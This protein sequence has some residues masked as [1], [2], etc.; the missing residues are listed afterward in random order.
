MARRKKQNIN[1]TFFW[2]G[3]AV[4]FLGII[5]ETTPG[6]IYGAIGIIVAAFI[7]RYVVRWRARVNWRRKVLSSGIHNIDVMKGETFEQFLKVLFEERGYQVELT[8][9]SGDF[10]ADL[11]MTKDGRRI[12]VQ[13]KRYE[14]TVG[15]DAIQEAAGARSYY[16][17]H[18]AIVITNQDF[19]TAARQQ[20]QKSN[21]GL[22][23]RNGLIDLIA[24]TRGAQSKGTA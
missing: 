21:V 16:G 17:T 5:Y 11:I 19:S 24:K 2:G 4:I 23:N 18:D 20:A 22:I 10:G 7:I 15:I 9:K 13:A 8:P 14:K 3:I 1:P 6:L 12:A